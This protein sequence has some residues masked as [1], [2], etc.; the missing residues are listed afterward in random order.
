MIWKLSC[1]ALPAVKPVRCDG[2]FILHRHRDEYGPHLDL[3]LEFDGHLMGWRID[4]DRIEGTHWAMLKT[5][6][7][8]RW[9]ENDSDAVRL[10]SGRYSWQERGQDRRR[11]VLLGQ[12]TTLQVV[13]K[14]QN[15]VTP[16]LLRSIAEVALA[17]PLGTDDLAG[18]IAD[19]AVARQR[20]VERLC[21]LGRELD[22]SAFDAGLW[23]K[24][25]D[26]QSLAEI[27]AHLRGFES[28]FDLKY[29]PLPV[30]RPEPLPEDETPDR[31][32]RAMTIARG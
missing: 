1:E 2:R 3:R 5:S 18:L 11:L 15:Y 16:N 6:H 17:H 28:R 12:T 29:P 30:S 14:R 10:E 21:A 23:R 22:G 4:G 8:V 26:G 9:L 27:Q 13:A 7:T 32:E 24:L 19:G 20:A 31:W 25:L